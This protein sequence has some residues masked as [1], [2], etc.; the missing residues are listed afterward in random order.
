MTLV[1][2]AA[3]LLASSSDR[4]VRGAEIEDLQP[5]VRAN[6]V[7]VG[8]R[9]SG[10]FD[11]DIERAI[12]TGL[13]V[14]FRY[15]VE[16]KRTRAIWLDS[17]VAKCELRT[18][19]AYDNLTKRYK[20]T[21]EVDGKIDATEVVADADAMRRFMTTFDSLPLFDLSELEPNEAYYVRVKGVLRER[22][23]LLLIPW[24]VGTDWKEARFNYVP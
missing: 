12:T 14:S 11:E 22:N 24:N 20:L 16:L 13:E 5:L 15:N 19:V 4:A 7:F 17:R 6:G 3:A 8:F 2:V 1:L 18:T 9:V 10:A 21:R 23:L